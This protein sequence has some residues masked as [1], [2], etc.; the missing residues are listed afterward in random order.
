MTTRQVLPPGMDAP[1]IPDSRTSLDQ[2]A[3]PVG[4][5]TDGIEIS[6]L[7]QELDDLPR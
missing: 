1:L 5:V 7:L 3:G 4:D 2:A 6:C